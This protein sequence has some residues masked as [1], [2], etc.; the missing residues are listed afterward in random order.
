MS[1]VL[2]IIFALL[3]LVLLLKS[4]LTAIT[5]IVLYAL[6]PDQPEARDDTRAEPTL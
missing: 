3:V 1:I 5:F 4:P 6:I 2:K